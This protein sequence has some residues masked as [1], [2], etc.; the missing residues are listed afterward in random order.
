MDKLWGDM[1]KVII[2]R[3]GIFDIYLNGVVLWWSLWICLNLSGIVMGK[4]C[5]CYIGF[6]KFLYLE[7]CF[8]WDYFLLFVIMLFVCVFEEFIFCIFYCLLVEMLLNK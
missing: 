2:Y 7:I 1:I 4:K 6:C 8:V 5:Y 3:E